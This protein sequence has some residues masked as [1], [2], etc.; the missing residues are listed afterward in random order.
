LAVLALGACGGGSDVPAPSPVTTSATLS[1]L[2][3]AVH[4]GPNAIQAASA[5]L[6]VIPASRAQSNLARLQIM[7][8]QF[9]QATP[10]PLNI[11]ACGVVAGTPCQAVMIV[12]FLGALGGLI[13]SVE[14]PPFYIVGGGTVTAPAVQPRATVRLLARDT[15]LRLS[16]KGAQPLRIDA[17]DA[18]GVL[19]PGRTY[20]WTTANPAIATVD[21]AGMVTARGVGRT[22][23]TATREGG[24]MAVPVLAPAIENLSLIGP[25]AAVMARSPARLQVAVEAAPGVT[26]AVRVTSSDPLVA[27]V[28]PDLQVQLHREGT[29]RFTAQ[30]LADTSTTATLT[31][32]VQPFQAALSWRMLPA[33]PR[34]PIQAGVHGLAGIDASNV[35]AAGCWWINRFNGTAW[36]PQPY[37]T[38][39]GF[40]AYAIAAISPTEVYALGNQI[41]R[42]NGSTW[43]QVAASVQGNNILAATVVGNEIIGVGT[44]GHAIRGRNS[45]WTAIPGAPV[46][47]LNAVASDGR[48]VYAVGDQGTILRLDG[49]RWQA[50]HTDQTPYWSSVVVRSPSEVYVAGVDHS[51]AWHYLVRRFDGAT[52]KAMP[53]TYA[54]PNCCNMRALVPS[55]T[56]LYAIGD[57]DLLFRLTDG[58]WVAE[59]QGTSGSLNLGWSDGQRLISAGWNGVTATKSLTSATSP[60][61]ILTNSP[62]YYAT[63]AQSPSF[64]VM[65]GAGGIDLFDGRSWASMR[66][67]MVRQISNI[68]GSSARDIWA[69]GNWGTFLRYRGVQWEPWPTQSTSWPN[70]VWGV[71]ADTVWSVWQ[72]GDI[73]RFDGTTWRTVFRSRG[74]LLA[75]HG[76]H[77]RYLLATGN[78]GK[79]WRFDGRLWQQ[80]DS[81][82]DSQIRQVWVYD[83]L[84]AFAAA[85]NTILERKNGVWKSW[86]FPPNVNFHWVKGTGP[87][88]VYAGGC[89][90][91]ILRYD[92]ESWRP[93]TSPNG[94]GCALSGW[95]F[96]TQ[97]IVAGTFNRMFYSGMSPTG[98]A[99]GIP[100]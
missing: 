88:D 63:W 22:T 47:Q 15:L 72:N 56:A 31:L 59:S 67:D 54:Q 51:V 27:T 60:W 68:W 77:S 28:D 76:L 50:V 58:T 11:G 8:A 70:D 34:G 61:S 5:E 85:G 14:T 23:V 21:S 3:P 75:I 73:M 78:D 9:G 42:W 37:F 94:T 57:N 40:C 52:W 84:T 83:T 91:E 71:A 96:P 44:S 49:S 13:D 39:Q 38:Q 41:W 2:I 26:R 65:G 32:Q 89:N 48:T 79:V 30:A 90:T 25:T 36:D 10:V 53:R 66:G 74:P 20:T 35:W 33:V 18:I 45:T 81:G 4:T 64:I 1:V 98:V 80:E 100:R 29:V 69:V 6:R 55:G 16:F 87:R 86:T 17:Y 99:P 92:G 97:G 43:S 19:L 93:F 46:V 82:T 12:R 24:S 62:S 95:I 7:A